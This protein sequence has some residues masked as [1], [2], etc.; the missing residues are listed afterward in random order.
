MEADKL[1]FSRFKRIRTPK[2]FSLFYSLLVALGLAC[3]WYVF[4]RQ[5]DLVSG[6]F[7]DPFPPSN[8]S[9]YLLATFGTAFAWIVVHGAYTNSFG[10]SLKSISLKD[11]Q[12]APAEANEDSILNRHLDE[13]LY[14]FQSTEYDL[15]VIEDLDPFEDPDIFVTL[16]EINGLINA[17]KGTGRRVRFLYALR[18][19]IFQN[20]DRTKFFE[21]II[22]IVPI[23]N[24][25]N[26]IDKVLEQG[27]RIDLEAR[28][29]RRFL[30][31]VSR[32]LTDLR[33]IRNVF[34]EYVVYAANVRAD[35]D[36][37]L[38]PNKMLALLIYK[39]VL[40]KDFAALHRQ[41]GVLSRVLGRYEDYVAKIEADI[42]EQ[43]EEMENDLAV[44]EAQA[45]RDQT[46]LR[47]VYAMAIVSRIPAGNHVLHTSIGNIGLGTLADSDALETIIAQKLVS[48]SG[49][50]MSR[51]TVHF[52][53]L[54]ESVDPTRSFK[55]RVADLDRKSSKFKAG[56][57]KRL[58]ELKSE[59]ASL[60]TRR[61]NEVV[62]ESQ[63][64]I[65]QL[66]SEVSDNRELLK[67]LILE[68]YLD[69]TY[70]QYTSLFHG[71]R[72]SPNDNNFLIQIRGYT[73][74][75]PDFPI[76]NAAEVIAS[77]RAEDFRH[78]YVLNRFLV[79][80]FLTH[81]LEY[82][83]RI[84]DAVEFIASH[85]EECGDFFRSYYAR[86]LRVRELTQAMAPRWPDFA[87]AALEAPDGTTHAA[88]V[89]AY[90]PDQALTVASSAMALRTKLSDNLRS[91]AGEGIDFDVDR[92][93]ALNIQVS[94]V[95]SLEDVPDL[96]SYVA[97]EGLYRISVDNIRHI[98][99]EVVG[100]RNVGDLE[101][102]HYSTLRKIGDSALLDRIDAD[103]PSYIS[104]L[105]SIEG[106]IAED[107]AAISSIMG[108]EDVDQEIR[109]QF[110]ERQTT[111]LPSLDCVP[112]SFH[113]FMLEGQH[114][115]PSWE[116]CFQFMASEAYDPD[117]FTSYLGDPET[118]ASLSR[119]PI[120]S[121]E[122][123][124]PLRE[125]V[126]ENDALDA[127]VYR[128]YVRQTSGT[129][130]E[131]PDVDDSKLNILIEERKVSFTPSTFASLDDEN[132][133]VLF[134]ATNFPSYEAEPE[135]Y[136]INDD[137][138]AKLLYSRLSDAQKLGLDDF[139]LDNS[140]PFGAH[141]SF[142]RPVCPC[143]RHRSA[144]CGRG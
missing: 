65:D 29:D 86:G 78:R 123:L 67:Y 38:D 73:N 113:R 39:N 59:L 118:A 111:S 7:F 137:F 63:E 80:H 122:T 108:R 11:M 112:A 109:T 134:I 91:I 32:Y 56:A 126:F 83:D 62:R 81:P 6:A 3:A 72:L 61:F 107:V 66:F 138:R 82:G 9:G 120:P 14:F 97:Q 85:F 141:S 53:D 31:E 36:A 133:Q 35:R 1:P 24:H 42:R 57:E 75:S 127:E 22:P 84:R 17:S 15:V 88:R 74:P 143:P 140:R 96:R 13:I 54:E 136:S 102:S 10:L 116:N 92:L 50:Y 55:E 37:P 26:S 135:Q 64:L 90:V 8:W 117:V 124:A 71:G 121:G 44:G 16:R 33:L 21:F 28:L 48:V 69:D 40:P 87:A 139:Y 52:R 94:D 99:K 30:R 114:V 98:V 43:I 77:M 89:L 144:S 79:D 115:E 25:S 101:T 106:N 76:D 47:K 20:T 41:E 104:M 19:D 103:F 2:R 68:G 23:I 5:A 58:R 70:Y 110:L 4:S 27:R 119:Q 51:D 132:L 131:F 18:D 100:W 125:F 49:T 45:L 60:R 129:L 93:R 130:I 34:N 46:D 105:L 12:I 95:A 142:S 128:A